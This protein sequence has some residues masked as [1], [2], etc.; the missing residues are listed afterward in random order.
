[1]KNSM[2]INLM[3]IFPL[4]V[5]LLA[6]CAVKLSEVSVPSNLNQQLL[7]LGVEPY[8]SPTPQ[9]QIEDEIHA[10][11]PIRLAY[12]PE[13]YS[14]AQAT[15]PDYD[16]YLY[17]GV[18]EHAGYVAE[19]IVYPNI[20]GATQDELLFVVEPNR[21]QGVFAIT[22]LRVIGQ[23]MEEYSLEGG[24]LRVPLEVPL[25][26]GCAVELN[27]EYHLELPEQAGIFGYTEDQLVLTNWYPFVL[28]YD[29]Q[30]G[31]MTN[32]PG[33]YG[34]HLVYQTADFDV[35][36]ELA[37]PAENTLVAAAAPSGQDGDR[38]HFS[39]ENARTF[40]LAVLN[41][42]IMRQQNLHGIEISVYSKRA[43]IDA[44]EASLS[45]AAA[46]LQV[47][48][49]VFGP[50]PFKSLTITQI[51]MYD[52]MEY[53]GIFFLSEEV[54]DTYNWSGRN[55]LTFLTVHEISHNWWFSQV[56]ND[57][58]MEPWLDEAL[59]TYCE[60]LFYELVD[61]E[62]V[63]WWWEFRVAE[64]EPEG[65]VDTSIYAYDIYE[66]YRRAV[67][68]RGV[69]FLQA[70]RDQMGDEDFFAF[71]RMYLEQGRYRVMTA[72]DFFTLLE[73]DFSVDVG[74]LRE[75]YFRGD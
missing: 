66:A 71:L 29:S 57:Q 53:D 15:R 3:L 36:L 42:Y 32:P 21:Q 8:V 9:A 56:G 34:E 58:A 59:A 37:D 23:Q 18:E 61:P 30:T 48:E 6:G 39:L 68:L 10:T 54:F 49:R 12:C 4:L 25:P 47:F 73:D 1:M 63:D 46:A 74:E 41:E 35:T 7:T 51:E 11:Q 75:E 38:Y 67:Y 50:Y 13:P 19:N 64:Y 62:L 72:E 26:E 33:S 70:L 22:D 28:P 43:T 55:M 40:S 5:I 17:L 60:V 16:L 14:E 27:I 45:T 24:E 52:G 69:E 44:V 31:W 65:D 2:E 20:T